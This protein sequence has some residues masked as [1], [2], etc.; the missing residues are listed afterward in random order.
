[1][2][3]AD[4]REVLAYTLL[5]VAD[6]L[7]AELPATWTAVLAESS[8]GLGGAEGAVYAALAPVIPNGV[9]WREALRRIARGR[10]APDGSLRIRR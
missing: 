2:T 8:A 6:F 5:D 9:S 10:T 4:A 3:D 1:M 7:A